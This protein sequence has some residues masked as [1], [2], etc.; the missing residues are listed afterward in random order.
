[1]IDRDAFLEAPVAE[2]APYAPATVMLAITGTRRAAALAG[3]PIQGE[4]YTAW[5]RAQMI[6]TLG[7]LFDHG[8][9]HIVATA[10]VPANLVEYAAMRDRYLDMAMR[11]MAGPEAQADYE[12]LQCR[13]SVLFASEDAGL[14]AQAEA[15]QAATAHHAERSLWW[16]VVTDRDDPWAML[17][18]AARRAPAAGAADLMRAMYGEN[19]PPA[20]L[21]LGFG[22]PIVSPEFM[23]PL[24]I[25]EMQCYWSER[26]GFSLDEPMLRQIIYDYSA[27]RPSQPLGGALDKRAW[28]TSHAVGLGRRLGGFWYPAAF[29][30]QGNEQGRS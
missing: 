3:V 29:P 22:K 13:T 23:P 6:R 14:R 1:M 21:F 19:I 4:Q 10:I 24:L 9:R 12:R 15:V 7:L 16:F 27:V 26:P 20:T 5:S 8:V 2:I 18:D 17:I 25:G 28:S 30:G 11:G